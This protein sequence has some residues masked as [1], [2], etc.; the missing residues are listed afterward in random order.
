MSNTITPKQAEYQVYL[1]ELAGCFEFPLLGEK[2]RFMEAWAF[3]DYLREEAGIEV[4][5]RFGDYSRVL[6]AN[7]ETDEDGLWDVLGEGDNA[8]LAICDA[9]RRYFQPARAEEAL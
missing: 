1:A 4:I 9:M 2:P 5:F 7:A 6:L 3:L 8:Y